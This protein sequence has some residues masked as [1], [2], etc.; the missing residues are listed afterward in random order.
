MFYILAGGLLKKNPCENM[1]NGRENLEPED[2]W[3]VN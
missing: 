1:L 3:L 2:E